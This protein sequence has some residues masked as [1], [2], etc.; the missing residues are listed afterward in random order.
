[1]D[2]QHWTPERIAGLFDEIAELAETN[3]QLLRQLDEARQ[4]RIHVLDDE[5]NGSCVLCFSGGYEIASAHTWL[6]VH[7]DGETVIRIDHLP[8]IECDTCGHQLVTMDDASRLD[9]LLDEAEQTEAELSPVVRLDW[10]DRP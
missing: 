10:L 7:P 3:H 5:G 6:A 4:R 2:D 9:T 8:V 1:M